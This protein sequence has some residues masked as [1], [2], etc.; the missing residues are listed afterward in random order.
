MSLKTH[1]E[2]DR[3]PGQVCI[4]TLLSAKIITDG[5]FGLQKFLNDKC[6]R[7][8]LRELR[9]FEKSCSNRLGTG[10]ADTAETGTAGTG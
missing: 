9:N 8:L 10:A 7:C 3:S 2:V 5:W 1:L 4:G 6:Y